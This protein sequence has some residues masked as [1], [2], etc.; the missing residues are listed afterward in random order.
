MGR[1]VRTN[2]APLEDHSLH[3]GARIYDLGVEEILGE[4]KVVLLSL[5]D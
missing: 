2:L 1:A 4:D 3:R 5:G